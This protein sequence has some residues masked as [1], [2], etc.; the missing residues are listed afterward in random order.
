MGP[1]VIIILGLT[2]GPCIFNKLITIVKNRLEA[3][4][5]MVVREKYEP[6]NGEPEEDALEWS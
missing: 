2:F 3:A 1:V 5:L 4:H 6:I